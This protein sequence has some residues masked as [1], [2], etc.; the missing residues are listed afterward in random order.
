MLQ[1]EFIERIKGLLVSIYIYMKGTMN[2]ITYA[3]SSVKTN[4]SSFYNQKL[5]HTLTVACVWKN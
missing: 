2:T 4:S 3:V 5:T 1:G